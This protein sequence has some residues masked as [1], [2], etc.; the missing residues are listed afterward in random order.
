MDLN[1]ITTINATETEIIKDLRSIKESFPWMDTA[2]AIT[3]LL[4]DVD[5][6]DDYTYTSQDVKDFI[7]RIY[8]EPNLLNK[9]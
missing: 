1:N 5:Q 2:D 3:N 7:D 4:E 8:Q 9:L 6:T